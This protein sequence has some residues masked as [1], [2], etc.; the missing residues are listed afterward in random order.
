MFENLTYNDTEWICFN[1]LQDLCALTITLVVNAE[2][3][4]C[5]NDK[6]HLM[7]ISKH[8]SKHEITEIHCKMNGLW[9]SL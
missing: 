5:R 3:N 8:E 4:I 1:L 7:N 9:G 2:I 6:I